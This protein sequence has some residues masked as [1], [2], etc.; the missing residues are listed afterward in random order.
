[1]PLPWAKV[2]RRLDPAR[3]TIRT[4]P[5]L[6]AKQGDP[7]TGVLGEAVDVAALLR[8]LSARLDRTETKRAR[9]KR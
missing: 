3:F 6:L 9:A 1:M 8:A 4:A 7:F 2:T 5:G